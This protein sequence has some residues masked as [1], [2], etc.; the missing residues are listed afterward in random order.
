[1]KLCKSIACLKFVFMDQEKQADKSELGKWFE[2]N[3]IDK[4]TGKVVV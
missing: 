3:E 4:D 1:M 2:S